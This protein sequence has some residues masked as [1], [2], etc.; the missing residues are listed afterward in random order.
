M[1][2]CLGTVQFG[3]DYG[4][5]GRS[6][7]SLGNSVAM[8]NYAVRNGVEAI[9]TSALYGDAESVV[10]E[11]LSQSPIPRENL[12]V[13]SKF[14][15]AGFEGLSSQELEQRL[16]DEAGISLSRLGLNRLDAYICHV[17]SAVRDDRVVQALG[18][19]RRSGLASRVGFSVYET[20]EAEIA[21]KSNVVD[22]LQIPFSIL[23]Q[24]MATRGILDMAVHKGVLLHSR[25]AYVQGLAL[26]GPESVPEHLAE[27][28]PAIARL[29]E[30]CR[31]VNLSR[32]VL[33]LAF[34]RSYAQISHLVFGVHDMEQLV[35]T[36]ESFSSDIP[37]D[38][39]R[40]A[41][42]LFADIKP[43]LVMPNKW[44]K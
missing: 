29:A 37:G 10:G 3:I 11:F 26:M 1:K 35:D 17:P 28:R 32:Q 39:V 13:V 18:A 25:S 6:K 22:F 41:Q 23:D 31:A 27:I 14:G 8:L 24:R 36:I 21:I 19:L 7:P 16:L 42:R 34:V 33:A 9:D 44:K 15:V 4:L 2:L 5:R 12:F 38:V 40:E 20:D 43:E 30:L